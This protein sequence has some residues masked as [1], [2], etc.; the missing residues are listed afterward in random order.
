MA[1]GITITIERLVERRERRSDEVGVCI[2]TGR[3]IAR[4]DSLPESPRLAHIYGNKPR[5]VV[6][7]IEFLPPGVIP[8]DGL[9][10][11][12][13]VLPKMRAMGLIRS[14]LPSSKPRDLDPSDAARLVA[15]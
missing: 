13:K 11:R 15:C 14:V 9:R 1:R 3:G 7:R 4:V 6:T 8:I 10:Y 2:R 5:E 12:K